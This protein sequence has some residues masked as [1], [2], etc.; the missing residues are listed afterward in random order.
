MHIVNRV[1]GDV[2]VL[3]QISEIRYFADVKR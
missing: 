3:V 1:M 2:V